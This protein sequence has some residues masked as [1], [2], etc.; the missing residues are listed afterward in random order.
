MTSGP[1]DVAGP[2]TVRGLDEIRAA[3][4]AELGP[5]PWI[6]VDQPMIDAFADVTGD[7]Q[8]IH[9]DPERARDSPFG[10]TIAHGYLTLALCNQ[11][12]PQLFAVEGVEMGI[13]YGADRVRFPAPLP[14]GT[15]IRGCGRVDACTDVPGGVQ[16]RITVTAEIEGGSRPACV[17]ETLSRWMEK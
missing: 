8:W 3:E 9:V 2:L 1:T 16:T 10:G 12:L 6:L 14:A 4:G 15:R 11:I 7:H 5:T 17:V 13:N